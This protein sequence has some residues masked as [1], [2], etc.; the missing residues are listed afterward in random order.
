MGSTLSPAYALNALA[1]ATKVLHIITALLYMSL[2]HGGDGH[3]S[4]LAYMVSAFAAVAA[5]EVHGVGPGRH[6]LVAAA[7]AWVTGPGLW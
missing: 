7:K 4:A 3:H 2:Y 5:P 1:A 6:N